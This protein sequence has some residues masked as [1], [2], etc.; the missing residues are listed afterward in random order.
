MTRAQ[1]QTLRGVRELVQL[2]EDTV[3][4]R[5]RKLR[6][7]IDDCDHRWDGGRDAQ[8]EISTHNINRCGGYKECAVCAGE[9]PESFVNVCQICKKQ[10]GSDF[11]KQGPLGK[12]IKL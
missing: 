8:K 11:V 4:R 6:R 2:A 10:I 9:Q 7:L 5:R 3:T 1:I 12:A